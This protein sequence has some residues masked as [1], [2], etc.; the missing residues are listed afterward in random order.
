MSIAHQGLPSS[1]VP[2][3]SL[4]WLAGDLTSMKAYNSQ[5]QLAEAQNSQSAWTPLSFRVK[6]MQSHAD[7]PVSH[8]VLSWLLFW[9]MLTLIARQAVYLSGPSRSAE[10]YRDVSAMA[11]RGP[12]N[13]LYVN[14]LFLLG[15]TLAGHRQVLQVLKRNLLIV[16]M[17]ALS[18]CS[19]LWSKSSATTLQMCIQVVLCTLFACYLSARLTAERL[20]QLLIFMGVASALLSIFFAVALPSYGIFEGYGGDAWQG[21]CTHK[22]TLGI[23][24][25]FLLTPVFFTNNYSRGR[26]LAYSALILFLIYKSQSRGA[27][28]DTLATLLFV[29]WLSLVRRLRARELAFILLITGTA[30][31]VTVGLGVHF[32]PLLTTELGKD[33]SASGR[34]G[35]YVEVFRSIMKHPILGY[36][37]GGFWYPGSLESKRI[38]LVLNWPNI[39]YSENGFLEVALQLGFVGV[40]LVVAMLA[41]AAVQGVRL[42]RSISY[43][44][45]IGWYVTLLF[46]AAMT[47]VDA[48]W[49]L[50]SQTLDW[51]LIVVSCVGLNDEMRIAISPARA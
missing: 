10:S 3:D 9:P 38:G 15:F 35:I 36:G 34:T 43:S 13:Y 20:M 39:G 21:I 32:W 29:A 2:N 27:W 50:T 41:K 5:W 31:L 7:I 28:I 4:T 6:R 45:R 48:G 14:L 11:A 17:L 40:A 1:F 30:G 33:A 37:F 49:F 46:L 12:H 51:V 19:A 25:V 8:Q 23:S 42:L 16:A 22:N 44:P 24:M 47:N 26:K 18:V